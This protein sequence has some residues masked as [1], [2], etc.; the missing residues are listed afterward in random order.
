MHTK[1]FIG[2]SLMM[3]LVTL[4]LL[5]ISARLNNESGIVIGEINST[6]KERV[7]NEPVVSGEVGGV[8]DVIGSERRTLSGNSNFEKLV[9]EE[10]FVGTLEEVNIGCFADGECYVVVDGKHVTTMIGWSDAAV[11]SILGV[12]GFGDL[13]YFIGE[14]VSV[15]AGKKEDGTYTLY[16]NDDYNV[17]LIDAYAVA[18]TIG[19]EVEVAGVLIIPKRI[20]EDNRCPFGMMCIQAGTLVLETEVKSA[21]DRKT[22]KTELGMPVVVGGVTIELLRAD[23]LMEGDFATGGTFYFGVWN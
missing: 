2:I 1:T 19:K 3:L 13:E 12:E 17:A 14:Q 15:F 10:R 7:D 4:S 20:L 16:Q 5:A 22:V 9:G 6:V 11:G 8:E 23:P 21:N 18:T